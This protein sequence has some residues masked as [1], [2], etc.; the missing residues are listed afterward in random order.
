M[1][2]DRN[3]IWQC[4]IR[5]Y[6]EFYSEQFITRKEISESDDEI[7]IYRRDGGADSVGLDMAFGFGGC[8]S[9]DSLRLRLNPSERRE[10]QF[11]MRVDRHFV[12]LLI[13]SIQL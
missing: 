7:D 9:V 6:F 8:R 12:E 4:A 13:F 5:K 11:A 1:G 3:N 10:P 2:I